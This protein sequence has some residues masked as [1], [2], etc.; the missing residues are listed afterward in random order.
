MSEAG[1]PLKVLLYS[2]DRTVREQVRLTL[3]RKVAADLAEIEIFEVA[4][5]PALLKALDSD[6]NYSL[7]ILDGEA[8]PAGGFGVAYQ[9]KDE[10]ANCPPVLLLVVRQVDSWLATWSRADAV[11][12]YPLDPF[13]LPEQA[14]NLLRDRLAQVG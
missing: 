14:A 7:L 10:V 11:A 12:P 8:R 9:V 6:E 1:A 4:T 13:Q 3:G 5:V 2:D